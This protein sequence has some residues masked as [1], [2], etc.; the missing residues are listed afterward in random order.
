M[1]FAK[2]IPSITLN[3]IVDLLDSEEIVSSP[4]CLSRSFKWVSS[5]RWEKGVVPEQDMIIVCQDKAAEQTAT[6]YPCLLYTSPS[7]RD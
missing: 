5:M 6:L 2:S 4:A 1:A 7:P 3:M